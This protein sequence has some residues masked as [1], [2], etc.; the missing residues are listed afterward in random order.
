MRAFFHRQMS[1]QLRRVFV[2]GL[3]L[4][5]LLGTHWLG[6]SHGISHSGLGTS[7]QILGASAGSQSC[8][9]SAAITHSS[10]SCHLFDALTLA[11]FVS[12]ESSV[13]IELSA[14]IDLNSYS[15][16]T[17]DYQTAESP[18][19]SQAPPRLIL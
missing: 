11:S 8:D 16:K 17:V 1:Q 5:C 14:Y 10:A 6:F 2:V 12:T 4:V 15:A 13:L 19:Q 9:E 7:S 18:Y 3:L